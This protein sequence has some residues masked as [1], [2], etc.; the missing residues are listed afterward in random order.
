MAAE[1]IVLDQRGS[2]PDGAGRLHAARTNRI[3]SER[4]HR[5]AALLRLRLGVP[6]VLLP[7][8]SAFRFLA[9]ECD[10]RRTRDPAGDRAHY[11]GS[12]LAVASARRR[13]CGPRRSHDGGRVVVHVV[14]DAA[15]NEGAIRRL[16]LP[17][18]HSSAR[19]RD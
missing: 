6:R 9:A 3:Q 2:E 19:M 15:G 16:H 17:R 13:A 10:P 18:V 4:G 12:R 1:R 8:V 5:A 7:R 14:F 11:R